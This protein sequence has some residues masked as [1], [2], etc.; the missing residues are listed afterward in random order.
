MSRSSN[1]SYHDGVWR[2]PVY[3]LILRIN[4]KLATLVPH[5]ELY[6][7]YGTKDYYLRSYVLGGA[8]VQDIGP[9][10]Y[11]HLIGLADYISLWTDK[12]KMHNPKVVIDKDFTTYA[13]EP[14]PANMAFD[15]LSIHIADAVNVL[16]HAGWKVTPP[17]TATVTNGAL[18]AVDDYEDMVAHPENYPQEP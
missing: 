5:R 9:V 18:L 10:Y 3:P 16:V 12:E 13:N 15:M 8:P 14:W 2:V 11:Q 17:V 4:R 7:R 1:V 6:H